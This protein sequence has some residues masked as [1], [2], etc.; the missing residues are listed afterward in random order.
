MRKILSILGI[1]GL[2]AGTSSTVLACGPKKPIVEGEDESIHELITEF[3][4]EIARVVTEHFTSRSE[5]FNFK[6]EANSADIFS[7]DS[8][9]KNGVNRSNTE[10]TEQPP[11]GAAEL[12]KIT[13][14]LKGILETEVLT[15]SIN[16]ISTDSNKFDVLT[17]NESIVSEIGFDENSIKVN[18][19]IEELGASGE[20]SKS[21]FLADVRTNVKISYKHKGSNGGQVSKDIK[22]GLSLVISD[23]A[24]IIKHL[25]DVYKKVQESYKNI[26]KPTLTWWKHEDLY[27]GTDEKS[28]MFEMYYDITRTGKLQRHYQGSSE[29]KTS[30]DS[31]LKESVGP[32]RQSEFDLKDVE[33]LSE[34]LGSKV[35]TSDR[36]VKTYEN[37]DASGVNPLHQPLFSKLETNG[38]SYHFDGKP[39]TKVNDSVYSLLNDQAKTEINNY[40]TDLKTYYQTLDDSEK[41]A[42]N[43]L[44]ERDNF[45][46]GSV[47]LQNI[48]LKVTDD[49]QVQLN[50]INMEWVLAVSGEKFNK[51]QQLHE[52]A[53]GS[54]IYFN[55]IKGIKSFHKAWGVIPSTYVVPNLPDLGNPKVFLT[56]T[57]DDGTGINPWDSFGG[58]YYCKTPTEINSFNQILS[59]QTDKL[60]TKRHL[61][62]NSG[63]Q[64]TFV[65]QMLEVG[66]DGTVYFDPQSDSSQVFSKS[67]SSALG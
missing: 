28:K 45:M 17:N 34:T 21:V 51:D 15:S 9:E 7:R 66:T 36:L 60:S 58:V 14:K 64:G 56:A 63:S 35:S 42:M 16:K 40:Q 57:G 48:V 10:A 18:Y 6:A 23:S 52:T 24:E 47:A 13:T 67:A 59:L 38:A 30:L 53:L 2:V 29:F 62:L 32:F 25:A 39:G 19:I 49:Y 3:N 43:D 26:A 8:L 20:D 41:L 61:L 12:E 31:I 65:L 33:V 1:V 46:N 55:T 37:N 11:I 44:F 5:K 50:T 22:P 54:A 27:A 4:A